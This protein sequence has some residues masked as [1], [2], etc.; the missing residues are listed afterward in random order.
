VS[1]PLKLTIISRNHHASRNRHAVAGRGLLQCA[2]SKGFRRFNFL[3]LIDAAAPAAAA[4][5]RAWSR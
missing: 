1:L 3:L 4:G 5:M 2:A